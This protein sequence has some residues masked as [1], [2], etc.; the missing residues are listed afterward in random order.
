MKRVF[1]YMLSIVILALLMGCSSE[2]KPDT[3]SMND[4]AIIKVDGNKK[5]FHGMERS[6]A[7]NILGRGIEG[8]FK[9]IN[10]DFGVS[11]RYRVEESKKETVA[12]ILLD[13]KSKGVYKTGRGAAIGDSREDLLELYGDKYPVPTLNVE[14]DFS[15]VYDLE[16][17]VFLGEVSLK[18]SPDP[19]KSDELRNQIGVD[20][21]FGKE[22]NLNRVFLY[23]RKMAMYLY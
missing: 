22:N 14:T 4:I 15:Y 3:L 9:Q 5:V 23:D 8:D 1:Q 11:I 13:E 2:F 16:S 10:Y 19:N 20:L 12:M 17:K 7:E 18:N 6:Q 21:L